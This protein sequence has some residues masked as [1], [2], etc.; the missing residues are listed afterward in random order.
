MSAQQNITR[1]TDSDEPM[2]S[3]PASVR[4]GYLVLPISMANAIGQSNVPSFIGD[5]LAA[6]YP[7]LW[8][9]VERIQ[10]LEYEGFCIPNH[11][12]PDPKIGISELESLVDTSRYSILV[13]SFDVRVSGQAEVRCFGG[14]CFLEAQARIVIPVKGKILPLTAMPFQNPATTQPPPPPHTTAF[15]PD[16]NALARNTSKQW[17]QFWRK[18]ISNPVVDDAQSTPTATQQDS[19]W[20]TVV[21]LTVEQLG[22]DPRVLTQDTEFIRDLGADSLDSVELVMAFEEEFGVEIPDEMAEGILSLGMATDALKEHG[23]GS[24]SEPVGGKEVQSPPPQDSKDSSTEIED[25]RS[26]PNA[27]GELIH[28][29]WYVTNGKIISSLRSKVYI[30]CGSD[31]DMI[32][33]LRER[34]NDDFR[35]AQE[36]PI[37]LEFLSD[38]S[39]IL[40][41]GKKVGPSPMCVHA[42]VEE[43]MG[44]CRALFSELLQ[45]VPETE[46]RYDAAQALVC[47]TALQEG[48]DGR[49][50]VSISDTTTF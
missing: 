25:V 24:E 18:K 4:K 27:D 11:V 26:N 41:D 28:N 38:V 19:L 44:G 50:S 34:A 48:E 12:A 32:Q 5:T 36:H 35:N 6:A 9:E 17:W 37:P 42:H 14:F 8:K 30:A 49:L 33:F 7:D 22:V 16:A 29:L 21:R 45:N 3:D 31:E 23:F 20:D 40:D 2:R 43:S 1:L 46:F 47:V 10:T 39:I 13:S 15:V